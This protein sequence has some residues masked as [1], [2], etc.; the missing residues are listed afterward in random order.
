MTKNDRCAKCGKPMLYYTL[1]LW[2][3]PNGFRRYRL[4]NKCKGKV[5]TPLSPFREEQRTF[6]PT[7]PQMGD[8]HLGGEKEG[9]R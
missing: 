5:T 2:N 1:V 3:G 6:G 8:R 9:M 4:C 7:S